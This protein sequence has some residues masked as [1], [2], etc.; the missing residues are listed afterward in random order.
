LRTT[1][2]LALAFMALACLGNVLRPAMAAA[3]DQHCFGGA[4]EDQIGC[5]QPASPSGSSALAAHPIPV[6]SAGGVPDFA[7]GAATA[8]PVWLSALSRD[9]QPIAPFAPRSPPLA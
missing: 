8:W 4:C 3:A 1:A 7:S 9:Q 6:V 5:G 2:V